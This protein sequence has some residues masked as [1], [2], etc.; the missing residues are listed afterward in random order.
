MLHTND[1]TFGS[2]GFK[3]DFFFVYPIV[4]LCKLMTFFLISYSHLLG[5]VFS[6]VATLSACVQKV[7]ITDYDG[8]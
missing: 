4:R 3:E 5:K 1:R 2:C 8:I 7:K 6:S